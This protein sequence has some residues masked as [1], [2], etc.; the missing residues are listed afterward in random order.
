MYFDITKHVKKTW[1]YEDAL[2]QVNNDNLWL[3]IGATQTD[4]TSLGSSVIGN[5]QFISEIKYKDA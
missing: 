3:A 4:G 5:Y 1:M 2:S